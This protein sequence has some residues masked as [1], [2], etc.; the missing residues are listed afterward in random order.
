MGL[1]LPPTSLQA[2]L[3]KRLGLKSRLFYCP[4][5]GIYDNLETARGLWKAPDYSVSRLEIA[6]LGF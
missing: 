2:S 3:E 6:S 4:L 5:G 1:A